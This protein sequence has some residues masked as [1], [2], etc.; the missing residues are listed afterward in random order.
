[1]AP[2]LRYVRRRASVGRAGQAAIV[3]GHPR[4]SAGRRRRA[5]LLGP[6]RM[7]LATR[8]FLG[9]ITVLVASANDFQC[10]RTVCFRSRVLL[11]KIYLCRVRSRGGASSS[12]T[13]RTCPSGPGDAHDSRLYGGTCGIGERLPTPQN[14]VLSYEGRAGQDLPLPGS[15]KSMGPRLHVRSTQFRE[16]YHPKPVC[17]SHA[18]RCSM[19]ADMLSLVSGLLVAEQWHCDRVICVVAMPIPRRLSVRSAVC[20]R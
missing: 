2:V 9:S 19:R 16:L 14:H 12:V 4:R 7:A 8:T 17:A 15:I 10:L 6:V 18:R 13:V 5:S 20:T 3:C 11:A 1:M